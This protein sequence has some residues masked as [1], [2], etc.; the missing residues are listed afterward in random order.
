MDSIIT[1]IVTAF[2]FYIVLSFVSAF[3][4]GWQEAGTESS[5]TELKAKLATLTHVVRE[6]QHAG[7]AY[8]FDAEDDRFLAWGDTQAEIIATLKARWPEH[9]FYL[10]NT[11][12][13]LC[14]P[15][16]TPKPFPVNK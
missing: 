7:R 3:I 5:E 4:R 16:W 2:V 14:K 9:I 13:I 6:E 8:W 12:E 15:E 10:N 1:F 11:Q